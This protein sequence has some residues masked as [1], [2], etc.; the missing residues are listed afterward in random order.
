MI[1]IMTE[2]V[3]LQDNPAWDEVFMK[4]AN[5]NVSVNGQILAIPEAPIITN[6]T[7]PPKKPICR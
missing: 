1:A 3:M 2:T 7:V 4:S 6:G 5:E